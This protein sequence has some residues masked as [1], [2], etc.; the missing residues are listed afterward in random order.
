MMPVGVVIKHRKTGLNFSA[1]YRHEAFPRSGALLA[2]FRSLRA[3]APGQERKLGGEGEGRL[4]T[5]VLVVGD[6][7]KRDE[8]ARQL[9]YVPV[10]VYIRSCIVSVCVCVSRVSSVCVV[11]CCEVVVFN[12]VVVLGAVVVVG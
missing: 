6:S 1:S 9:V 12:V 4:Q 5:R 3:E 8:A 7:S 11:L 10:P 2:L